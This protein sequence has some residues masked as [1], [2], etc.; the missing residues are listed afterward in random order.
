ML[1]PEA[2]TV[3]HVFGNY[4]NNKLLRPNLIGILSRAPERRTI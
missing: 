3:R 2:V 1:V 4:D